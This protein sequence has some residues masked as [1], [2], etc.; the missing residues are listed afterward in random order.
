MCEVLNIYT[1]VV[2][3]NICVLYDKLFNFDGQFTEKVSK[4]FDGE[5]LSS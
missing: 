5:C 1:I 2:N 3:C 4:L